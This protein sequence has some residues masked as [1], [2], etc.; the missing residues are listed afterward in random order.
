MTTFSGLFYLIKIKI[1]YSLVQITM[2]EYF[3][4]F[5]ITFEDKNSIN[6]IKK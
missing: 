6:W 3:I 1:L 2:D 4:V 5:F